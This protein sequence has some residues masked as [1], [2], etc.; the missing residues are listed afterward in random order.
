MAVRLPALVKAKVAPRLGAPPSLS[1][2]QALDCPQNLAAMT[3]RSDT[4]VFQ[5]L[6]CQ[7]P[8]NREIDIVVSKALG[9]LGHPK[10]FEPVRNLLHR[11][12]R[13]PQSCSNNLWTR[14][15]EIETLSQ[16]L[17]RGI[18]RSSVQLALNLTNVTR[19]IERVSARPMRFRFPSPRP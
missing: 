4:E 17:P 5:I 6:I 12:H 18:C 13:T 3:K 7:I 11:G 2:G 1:G 14:A 9:V 8:E 10:L 15:I 19:L 16:Y